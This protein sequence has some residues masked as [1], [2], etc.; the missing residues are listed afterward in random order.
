V[1]LALLVPAL[2]WDRDGR[3]MHDKAA[4]TALVRTR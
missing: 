2:I 3:G 1:L 4:G